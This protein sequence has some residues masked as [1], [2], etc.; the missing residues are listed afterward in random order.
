MQAIALRLPR[1]DSRT[2]RLI[3]CVAIVGGLAI[4]RGIFA[5]TIDLR[6]DEAYY[7][8]WSKESVI[9]Y[10]D[11][12]PLIAWCIRATTQLFGDTNFGVR[13]AGLAAMLIMQLL[14]ADIVRR[15]THDARYVVLALLLPEASLDYGLGLAKVTPDLALIPCEMAMIWSLV[16]LWQSDDLRWW[17]AAGLFGGLALMSKYT[18]V[19]LL[20]AVLAFA[21]VPH[22]RRRQLA[23]PWFWGS[24]LVVLIVISPMLY[25][26][27]VHDWAD[28]KSVV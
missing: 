5:A 13:F 23:S 1:Q 12:P 25:W 3:S 2:A 8:T 28:R 22:W 17:L 18:A 14:Q 4:V 7:W 15:M 6:V 20:P 9:S 16:R 10:L 26:N 21:F 27:A 24:A 11:H 19:L